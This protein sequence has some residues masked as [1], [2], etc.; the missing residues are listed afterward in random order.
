MDKDKRSTA[1]ESPVFLGEAWFDPI[2]L[3]IR[4]RIRGFIEVLVDE[5]LND[6]LGRARYQRPS[7]AADAEP[8]GARVGYR[9]GRDCCRGATSEAG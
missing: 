9:H 5:E 1:T 7:R 2:E 8:A 6:A 3:G 4:D